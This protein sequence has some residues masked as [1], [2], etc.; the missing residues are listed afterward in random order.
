MSKCFIKC[1]KYNKSYKFLFFAIILAFL[2]DIA[3][4][5]P[6]VIYF[7]HLKLFDSGNISNCFL[8]R[9]TFCYLFTIIFS[10][11]FYKIENKNSGGNDIFTSSKKLDEEL[12]KKKTDDIEYIHYEIQL[13]EYP[14]KKLLTIF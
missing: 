7:E 2:K 9:Q 12:D 11:I 13:E 3:L 6:N 5:S 4:G 1:G 14:F 8:V 10:Y